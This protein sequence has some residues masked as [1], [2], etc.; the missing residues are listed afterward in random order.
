[1]RRVGRSRVLRV[2]LARRN[3]P[4]IVLRDPHAHEG[5]RHATIPMAQHSSTRIFQMSLAILTRSAS[6]L[7]DADRRSSKAFSISGLS[8]FFPCWPLLAYQRAK[9]IPRWHSAG[10]TGRTWR[11]KR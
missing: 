4:Q 8:G 11:G 9:G 5:G 3:V 10:S 7:P 2:G 1:M 6:F